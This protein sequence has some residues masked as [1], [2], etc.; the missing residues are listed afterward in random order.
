MNDSLGNRMKE[1]YEIRNK[2]SVIFPP[3]FTQEPQYFA[4]L[5]PKNS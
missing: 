4:Y 3:I 1:N 2:W 5:I